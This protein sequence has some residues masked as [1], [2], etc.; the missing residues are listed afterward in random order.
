MEYTLT[1]KIKVIIADDHP[2]MLTGIRGVLTT[3]PH[4]EIIGEATDGKEVVEKTRALAPDIVITDISMPLLNGFEVA[5]AI[6]DTMPDVKVIILSMYEDREYV[7]EF[8]KTG[9]SGYVLKSNSPEELLKAVDVVSA[10]KAYFSP[11][12]SQMILQECQRL[13]PTA[14][15]GLTDREMEVLRFIARG[16]SS[17]QIAKSMYISPRTVAKYR[18]LIMRKLNRHS[19]A[20]LTQYAIS[21]NLL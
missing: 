1:K 7:T 17:K 19:V 18:E 15:D 2:M 12:V 16:Y 13:G 11:S 5:R 9:A 10:G 14:P 8:L 20:E 6:R 21:H 3:R 4:I